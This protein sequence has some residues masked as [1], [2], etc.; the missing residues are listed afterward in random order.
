MIYSNSP[1][2]NNDPLEFNFDIEIDDDGLLV[3]P[4]EEL[5]RMAAVEAAEAEEFE[6]AFFEAFNEDSEPEPEAVGEE[7]FDWFAEVQDE[8]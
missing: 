4:Q 2:E 6:K 7:E 3:I 8:D 1:N 5:D